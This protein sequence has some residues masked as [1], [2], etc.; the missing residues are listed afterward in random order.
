[1]ASDDAYLPVALEFHL[2]PSIGKARMTPDPAKV[3]MAEEGRL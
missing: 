1:M 3:E 2:C